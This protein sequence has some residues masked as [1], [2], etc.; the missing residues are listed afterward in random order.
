[1][2][3]PGHRGNILSPDARELG[4]GVVAETEGDRLAFLATEL[5]TRL[6]REVRVEDAPDV[7]AKEL[8]NLRRSK[9]L[10]AISV[11]ANL[12]QAAQRAADRL[13]ADPTLDQ[14]DLLERAT[15]NVDAPPKGAKSVGAALMLVADLAQVAESK[16][17]LDPKL[18]WIGVG[19]ARTKALTAAPWIVV[20]VF[21]MS[22]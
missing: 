1:M 21:G 5:F 18:G 3:S 16:R 4:I 13:A 9:K 22:R 10:R 19:V 8:A 14:G 12:A 7:V 11:D 6:A 17:W 2:E 20:L 15:D